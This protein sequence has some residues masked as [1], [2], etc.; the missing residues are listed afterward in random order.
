LF[1][2]ARRQGKHYFIVGRA[3]QDIIKSGGYKLSALD[4]EREIL[5]LP[6][7]SEVIVVGVT[8]EEFGQ[9]VG[10]ILSIQEEEIS[11][12]FCRDHGNERFVLTLDDLRRDLRRRLA[13]YKLPT[14]LRVVQ[15][16]LPKTASGKVLKKVLGAKYFPPEYP[17]IPEVQ[18]WAAPVKVE[19]QSKL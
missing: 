14:L 19:I 17:S 18:Y 5:S 1:P 15:G 12:D 4:I 10:A 11:E 7:I 6:Y 9:R 3:S 2:V 13:G 8:D 16:D